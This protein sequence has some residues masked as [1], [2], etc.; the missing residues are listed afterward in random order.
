MLERVC[1]C[2]HVTWISDVGCLEKLNVRSSILDSIWSLG[3]VQDTGE[4]FKTFLF[5]DADRYEAQCQGFSLGAPV[6]SPPSSVNC[7]S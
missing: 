5:T 2:A 4:I 7:F 3:A 6:S 1:K